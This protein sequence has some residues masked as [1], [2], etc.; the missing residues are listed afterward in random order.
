LGLLFGLA[1]SAYANSTEIVVVGQQADKAALLAYS[2]QTGHI[3]A[4]LAQPGTLTADVIEHFSQRLKEMSRDLQLRQKKYQSRLNSAKSLLQEFSLKEELAASEHKEVAIAYD[5]FYL[6]KIRDFRQDIAFYK[7]R[8][9]QIKL[10]EFDIVS[11]YKDLSRARMQIN[12]GGLFST[13]DPLYTPAT[14]ILGWE[15][16]RLYN[17]RLAS[18]LAGH[19]D[20]ALQ[21][22]KQGAFWVYLLLIV[23]A[24]AL[25]RFYGLPALRAAI[26]R[27]DTSSAYYH[28]YGFALQWWSRAVF[29]AVLVLLLFYLFW[30]TFALSEVLIVEGLVQALGDVIAYLVFM[31]AT[32][33]A[34]W[35]WVL[36]MPKIGGAA[37]RWLLVVIWQ[38]GVILF[39]NN[40]TF[41]DLDNASNPFY[42][43]EAVTLVNFIVAVTLF[44]SVGAFIRNI[45]RQCQQ[46]ESL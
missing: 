16:F 1:L 44:V 6:Q 34:V 43:Y 3:R 23:G 40:I 4:R 27:L 35:R 26:A 2:E 33:R 22:V 29:P 8:L 38:I 14:W 5:D 41:F 17:H 20:Y 25:Y 36:R 46:G 21:G 9:L 11:T 37:Y 45:R 24:Y 7:A 18:A 32:L 30:R 28:Y 10:I 12:E 19:G 13:N 39:A 42:T 31:T 15:S